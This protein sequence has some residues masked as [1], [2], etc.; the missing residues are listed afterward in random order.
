MVSAG[1]PALGGVSLSSLQFLGAPELL[2]SWLQH[3]GLCFHL[4]VASS[5]VSLLLLRTPVIGFR[6]HLNPS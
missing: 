2:G 5:S 4:P 6:D 1:L 3:P